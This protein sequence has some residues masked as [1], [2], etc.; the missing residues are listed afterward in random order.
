MI[1][2]S[3]LRYAGGKTRACKKLDDILIEHFDN[4]KYD[5]IISPFFGGGSFEFYLQNRYGYNIIANDKFQPL[6]NFWSICKH[7][8]DELCAKLF[9]AINTITKE[10]FKDFRLFIMSEKDNLIQAC[11][12][13]IIN[14]CSFNAAT[15]SGG[16]SHHNSTKRF[17][18]SSIERIKKLNLTEFEILNMDFE[19]FILNNDRENS[20][21]F[22]DPPYCLLNSNLYG[23]DGDMHKNFDHVRLQKCLSGRK[24][25]LMTYNDCQYIREIYKDYKIIETSWTYGINKSKKSSEIVIINL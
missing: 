18:T 24:N 12:Y 6:V 9:P 22:L 15:L 19:E 3:P 21:L 13:F 20:L 5:N 1:N 23:V 7:R 25:W 10:T 2:K 16:F 4:T 14:R 11:M 8:N 17:T